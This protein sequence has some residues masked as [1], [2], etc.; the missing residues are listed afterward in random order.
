MILLY[1]ILQ[2]FKFYIL[3]NKCQPINCMLRPQDYLTMLALSTDGEILAVCML[4]D[5][6]RPCIGFI[7]V[8]R[9]RRVC[10]IFS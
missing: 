7:K 6:T 1:F 9:F 2:Q 8:D 3:G 5:K 10:T 4:K